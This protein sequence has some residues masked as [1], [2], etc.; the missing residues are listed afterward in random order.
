[1]LTI[2][3]DTAKRNEIYDWIDEMEKN[4]EAFDYLRF[5]FNNYRLIVEVRTGTGE[6]ELL[7]VMCYD[8]K[9]GL[10]DCALKARVTNTVGY[11]WDGKEK[12]ISAQATLTIDKEGNPITADSAFFTCKK[13]IVNEIVFQ[14]SLNSGISQSDGL[15]CVRV[16]PEDTA[17]IDQGRY[18]YDFQIGVGN[19]VFTIMIGMLSIEQDIS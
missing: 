6:D 12:T 18:Y 8:I 15:M 3:V 2:K 16:A 5:M 10:R 14:K 11:F 17:D 13:A 19:D 7:N 1:M 9:T 4:G